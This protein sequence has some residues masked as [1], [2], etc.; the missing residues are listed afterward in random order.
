MKRG[1]TVAAV[2]VS[3]ALVYVAGGC[4]MFGGGPSDEELL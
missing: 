2:V 1:R 3:L 4:A